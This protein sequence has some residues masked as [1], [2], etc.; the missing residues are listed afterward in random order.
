MR[1]S[2]TDSA[3]HLSGCVNG[4]IAA[5]SRPG[6]ADPGGQGDGLSPLGNFRP[7]GN[8]PARRAGAVAAGGLGWPSCPA[9]RGPPQPNLD[10]TRI[11]GR[12]GRVNY[13]FRWLIPRL[14]CASTRL[15]IAMFGWSRPA[16]PA[17]RTRSARPATFSGVCASVCWGRLLTTLL[18]CLVVSASNCCPIVN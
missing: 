8:L 11:S 12:H 3:I 17:R 14:R 6:P 2:V 15:R 16:G 10:A 4:T 13:R 5:P 9:P 1:H 18:A 7:F